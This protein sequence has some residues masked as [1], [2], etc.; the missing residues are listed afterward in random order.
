MSRASLPDGSRG[1][2]LLL[3]GLFVL[4]GLPCV[5]GWALLG[6][7]TSRLLSSRGRMRAFNALMGALLA[8]SVVPT[9][10]A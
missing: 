2:V 9:L 6:A 7:G 1:R 3:A 4:V 5:G 10:M 8:A